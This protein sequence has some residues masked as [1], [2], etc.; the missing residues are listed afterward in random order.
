MFLESV[1]VLKNVKNF[2]NCAT[3]F[4]RLILAGHSSCKTPVASGLLASQSPSHEKDIE[5]FKNFWVF[6][7]SVTQFGDWF[8]SGSSSHKFT[9]NDLQLSSWLACEWTSQ[10]RKTL[11]QIFQILPQGF[12]CDLVWRL[13]C[14]SFQ[15]QKSR[16]LHN[17]GLFQDR[18]QKLFSFPSFTLTVHCLVRSSLSQTHRVSLKNPPFSSSSLLQTSRKGMGFLFFSKYFMFIS[19]F[20]LVFE[21]LLRF[22]KCDVRIWVGFILLSLLNGVFCFW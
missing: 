1:F 6:N 9:Q 18:F 3:L 22:E 13:V 2:K 10:S 16:V 20:S 4:W 21:L 14:D 17:D 19:F 12:F 5:K 11:G 8:A 7:I 15:S